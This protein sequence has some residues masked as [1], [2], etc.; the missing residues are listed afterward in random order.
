[1]RLYHEKTY[2][3][4]RAASVVQGVGP[5]FKLQYFKKKPKNKQTKKP[6]GW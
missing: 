1:M 3:K 5:E 2:Q 4:K 6:R